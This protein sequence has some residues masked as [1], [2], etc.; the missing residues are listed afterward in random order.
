MTTISSTVSS[1]PQPLC[2]VC[3]IPNYLLQLLKKMPCNHYIHFNCLHHCWNTLHT[4]RNSCPICNTTFSLQEITMNPLPYIT[5]VILYEKILRM[6]RRQCNHK[7]IDDHQCQNREYPFRN[8]MCKVHCKQMIPQ[9]KELLIIFIMESFLYIQ[10]YQTEFNVIKY[11]LI[12]HL[13]I[14][15]YQK[16]PSIYTSRQTLFMDLSNMFITHKNIKNIY[17]HFGYELLDE[18]IDSIKELR[19]PDLIQLI[20]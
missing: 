4:A 3:K 5:P 2:Q 1:N 14:M 20:Q 10:H 7:D 16:N 12:Y 11:I 6:N 18:Y 19:K 9:D 13:Y 15:R 8:R 17:H